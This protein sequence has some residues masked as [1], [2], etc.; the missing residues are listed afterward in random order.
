M[1][2]LELHITSEGWCVTTEFKRFEVITECRGCAV[3]AVEDC[4]ERHQV[5]TEAEDRCTRGGGLGELRAGRTAGRGRRRWQCT[6][7]CSVSCSRSVS[8]AGRGHGF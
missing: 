6:S 1:S 2:V 4:G 3:D 7:G 5:S 8:W